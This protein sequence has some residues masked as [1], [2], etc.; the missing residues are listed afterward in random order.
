MFLAVCDLAIF[1]DSMSAGA[2]TSLQAIDDRIS[3]DPSRWPTSGLVICSNGMKAA[4]T[5]SIAGV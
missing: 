2:P 4:A 5:I 1:S 3:Y